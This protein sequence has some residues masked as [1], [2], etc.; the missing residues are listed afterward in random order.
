MAEMN[1]LHN[2]LLDEVRDLYDAEK[3]LLKALPKMAKAASNDDLR[4]AI[5][6]HRTETENQ[7]TRLEQ[8][9]DLLETKPRGKHCAGMAG[10]I[11]EGADVLKE[12]ASDAVLDACIIAAAQ[13]A[14]HYEMAAYG[15]SA[16]W[17]EGLGLT[18][19]ARLL[20]ATLEEEKAADEKLSELAEAGINAA[21]GAGEEEEEKV[22]AATR[23]R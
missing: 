13:R 8:I 19:V 1:T 2:A 15:T 3:Q 21:A 5:E 17:A 4:E 22:A 18:D 23:R 12:D 7:V 10:I 20:R 14:E 16:A 9:F 11:E 6:S